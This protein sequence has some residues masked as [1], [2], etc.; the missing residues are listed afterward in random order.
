MADRDRDPVTTTTSRRAAAAAAKPTT[1]TTTAARPS[2]AARVT[3]SGPAAV[4]A[5]GDPRGIDGPSSTTDT[6]DGGGGSSGAVVGGV[7]AGVV[8][9]VALVGLLVYKRRKRT[10]A[11]A[12]GKGKNPSDGPGSSNIVS[13]P[14]ALA[15]EEGIEAAPS[16]HSEAQFR[17]QQQFPPGMRDELF[18][19]PGTA[20][21]ATLSNKKD[22][23]S[24]SRGNSGNNGS[25]A[26][27]SEGPI[28]AQRSASQSK[29]PAQGSLTPMPE[30]YMGK[31]DIDPR[32]DLRGL[33]L[34]ETYVK[35]A[36]AAAAPQTR[37][38][39]DSD[40]ES[41][42]LTLEE[43][44]QAHNQ[45]MMGHKQSIGSVNDLLQS[46]DRSNRP[47]DRMVSMATTESSMSMMPPLP[48]VASPAPFQ[49]I[50]HQHQLPN[51]PSRGPAMEDPYAEG[52]FTGDVYY[53]PHYAAQQADQYQNQYPPSSHYDA[54]YSPQPISPSHNRQYP[55][56]PEIQRDGPYMRQY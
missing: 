1:T 51:S 50:K 34:P 47:G 13:G 27:S 36:Q 33:E 3:R 30:Y 14:M 32:R 56:G 48:P 6:P 22:N 15:P 40:N 18:A 19:Q 41:V 37:S 12:S 38:S 52:A 49:G 7:A 2:R 28:G 35:M 53:N 16:H 31:E 24:L 26:G 21:H 11:G 43:A 55:Q 8:A 9:V 54:P 5:S 17:K 25:G 39:F 20:L 46:S 10:P 45:K 4:E 29:D 44:Q 23:G 42:Y